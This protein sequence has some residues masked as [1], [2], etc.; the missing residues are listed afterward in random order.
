MPRYLLIFLPLL[1]ASYG[2]SC[3]C[4]YESLSNAFIRSD[5]V[6]KVKISEIYNQDSLTYDIKFEILE[7]YK[8]PELTSATVLSGSE[9]G[10]IWTSCDFYVKQDEEWII[11]A[12]QNNAG[13]YN[14]GMCSKSN[15]IDRFSLWEIQQLE[16]PEELVSKGFF[17]ENEV[18]TLP[19]LSPEDMKLI[20]NG[21]VSENDL[22]GLVFLKV[23]VSSNADIINASEINSTDP[24]L[25][26]EAIKIVSE[27]SFVSPGKL[28]GN[29]V[30]SEL[31]I[32][33]KFK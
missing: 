16:N 15:Y 24:I 5:F 31:T 30:G 28:N 26:E 2:F 8:G 10:P 29:S 6:A 22:T 27:F 21:F 7:S 3:D 4:E 14:F 33:I 17:A 23:I 19:I 11:F 32:P 9:N 1:F 18:D 25:T 12:I 13:K 20:E